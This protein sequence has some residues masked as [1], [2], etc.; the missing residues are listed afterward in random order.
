MIEKTLYGKCFPVNFARFLRIPF[1]QNTSGRLLMWSRV[2]EFT[3]KSSKVFYPNNFVPLF[4]WRIAL[5][6][7][8]SREHTQQNHQ[9]RSS[10]IEEIVYFKTF[11]QNQGHYKILYQKQPSRGVFR[12][13]CSE[14]MQ[15]I[16]GRAPMSM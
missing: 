7:C 12:K 4:I 15:Q 2:M 10:R 9:K 5:H 8:C 16:Y 6:M 14:N 11:S 1:L 3:G 13:K